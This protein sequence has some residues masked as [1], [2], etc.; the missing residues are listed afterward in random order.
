MYEEHTESANNT[1]EFFDKYLDLQVLLYSEHFGQT[2]SDYIHSRGKDCDI[3]RHTA[4][5]FLVDIIPDHRTK[6]L[7]HNTLVD[8]AASVINLPT[9]NELKNGSK[10]NDK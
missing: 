1:I 5:A 6:Q 3:T 7:I 8:L 4:L 10:D 2:L 9:H